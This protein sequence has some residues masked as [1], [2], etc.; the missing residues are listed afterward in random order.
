MCLPAF[1]NT[2]AL[3]SRSLVKRVR[4][5]LAAIAEAAPQTQMRLAPGMH[6]IWNIE[7][8]RLFNEVLRSWLNGTI[9]PRL[10]PL[11]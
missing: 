3:C 5:S 10:V 8:S 1:A 6:H 2:P 4:Q 7:D 11:P 9:D